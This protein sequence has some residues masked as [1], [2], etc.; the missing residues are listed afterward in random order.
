MSRF[1]RVACTGFELQFTLNEPIASVIAFSTKSTEI[2]LDGCSLKTEFIR[3]IFA[4]LRRASAFV[5]QFWGKK[6]QHCQFA[7]FSDWS[8]VPWVIWG[9]LKTFGNAKNF[10]E[11]GPLKMGY[12]PWDLCVIHSNLTKVQRFKERCTMLSESAPYP[13][14]FL[15]EGLL[16]QVSVP[17]IL[18]N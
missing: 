13:N 9:H 4:A 8:G 15:P 17:M 5:G 1:S 16:D 12:G 2:R 3:A 14:P 10:F 11:R 6:K 7:Y 18:L